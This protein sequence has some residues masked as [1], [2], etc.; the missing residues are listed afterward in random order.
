[1]DVRNMTYKSQ[2]FDLIIDKSTIDV[3]FC[4]D[5]INQNVEL[6]LNEVH[7]ILKKGGFYVVI[8]FG[9]PEAREKYF[10]SFDFKVKIFKFKKESDDIKTTYHY[11]YVC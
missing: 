7:R 9:K 1:M 11:V 4:G 6:M 5:E 10:K 8:S 3:F 2:Y